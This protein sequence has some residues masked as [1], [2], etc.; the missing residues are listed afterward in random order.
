MG[1]DTKKH[2]ERQEYRILADEGG[3]STHGLGPGLLEGSPEEVTCKV[4][5]LTEASPATKRGNS[6]SEGVR[7]TEHQ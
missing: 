3:D 5:P 1:G 6:V 4:R 7:T 2:S